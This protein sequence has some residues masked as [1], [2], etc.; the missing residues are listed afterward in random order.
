M[1]C[2]CEPSVS[3]W[4]FSRIPLFHE[5][6]HMCFPLLTLQCLVR[7]RCE[8][9]SFRLMRHYAVAVQSGAIE[10]LNPD[11]KSLFCIWMCPT[12]VVRPWRGRYMT[13]R[14]PVV[15]RCRRVVSQ[16]HHMIRSLRPC[17]MVGG[18][19]SSLRCLHILG[20]LSTR[21][22]RSRGNMSSK[23]WL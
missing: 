11:N 12:W 10:W 18:S 5:P 4:Q 22:A 3:G 15:N 20:V 6:G 1:I 8:A 13:V 7:D 23:E 19:C 9:A 17:T 14:V 2:I 21:R 16:S